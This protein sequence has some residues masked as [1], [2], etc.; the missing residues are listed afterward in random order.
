MNLPRNVLRYV[1]FDYLDLD[2]AFKVSKIFKYNNEKKMWHNKAHQYQ[3]NDFNACH[4]VLKGLCGLCYLERGHYS[5]FYKFKICPTCRV[6]PEYKTLEINDIRDYYLL[7]DKELYA[8]NQIYNYDSNYKPRPAN[9]AMGGGLLFL[10]KDILQI[11]YKKYN[12]DKENLQKELER[13][14][15]LKI[16]ASLKK[17]AERENKKKATAI[18]YNED[19]RLALI[20]YKITAQDEEQYSVYNYGYHYYIPEGYVIRICQIKYLFEYCD[21]KRKLDIN[22]DEE[23]F[24]M[25]ENYVLSKIGNKYPSIFPWLRPRYNIEM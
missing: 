25:A 9:D 8:L 13:L 14:R 7:K 20:K 19:L 6:L 18:K 4:N 11:C 12:T 22:H 5:N 2:T 3:C 23:T 16:E 10:E 17:T 21:I 15:S 24:E 1:L